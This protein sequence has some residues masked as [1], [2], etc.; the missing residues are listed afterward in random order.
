ML[1]RSTLALPVA[2]S[3][4]ACAHSKIPET[5]IDDTPENREVLSVVETY[6]TA[7]EARDADKIIALVSPSF[8]EDNGNTDAADDY[9]R[10]GLADALKKD[11]ER[12]KKVQLELRI[13]DIQ[14]EDQTAAAF[15]FYTLRAHNDYPAGE[16]WQTTTDRSRISLELKDGRWLISSG[17]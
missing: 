16:K 13:D 4:A 3:L 10:N 17:I 14:V 9:D 11:F 12:T 1:P 15:V 2:F 7:F 8:Y 6:K 5:Q